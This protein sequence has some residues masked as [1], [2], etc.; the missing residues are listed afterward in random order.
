MV[1]TRERR[2][3]GVDAAYA[4]D[5]IFGL[6]KAMSEPATTLENLAERVARTWAA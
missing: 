3:M 5:E 2:A 4:M 6:E 1:G